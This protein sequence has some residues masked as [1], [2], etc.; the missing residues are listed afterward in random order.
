LIAPNALS[1]QGPAACAPLLHGP[2]S[3]IAAAVNTE[4]SLIFFMPPSSIEDPERTQLR[5]RKLAPLNQE[6][7][8]IQIVALQRIGEAH[9]LVRNCARWSVRTE[10]PQ[11]AAKNGI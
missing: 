9:E 11:R 8:V 5:Q 7:V 6:F 10:R 1:F 4:T 3:A 2:K